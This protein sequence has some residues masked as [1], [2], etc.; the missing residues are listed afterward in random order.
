MMTMINL[1]ARLVL[2]RLSIICRIRQLG[3]VNLLRLYIS[4]YGS[5]VGFSWYLCPL[6]LINVSL[7]Y[8]VHFRGRVVGIRHRDL[9]FY[10]PS[11]VLIARTI[12]D[13]PLISL[14]GT[15]FCLVVYCLGQL[16]RAS[17][18]FFNYFSSS[19]SPIFQD[20]PLSH[21]PRNVQGRST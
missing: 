9:A 19:F 10:R 15:I 8:F 16:L 1:G 18:L 20:P 7:N 2:V 12:L 4:V 21:M 5:T 6:T 11:D 13:I 3:M 17:G 14:Q